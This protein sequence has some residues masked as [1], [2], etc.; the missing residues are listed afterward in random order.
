MQKDQTRTIALDIG[1]TLGWAEALDSVIVRSGSI[2]LKNTDER[3]GTAIARLWDFLTQLVT[4]PEYAK[5][6]K[7]EFAYEIVNFHESIHSAH[8][9]GRILG[10]VE[11]FTEYGNWSFV[12]YNVGVIKKNFTGK[13][14]AKKI[15]M[16][17]RCHQLGWK[18]GRV[19]TDKDN[20]EADAI[21]ILAVHLAGRNKHIEFLQERHYDPIIYPEA[22]NQEE[23]YTRS[24]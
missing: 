21:A 1:T 14:N 8:A 12:S 4:A 17:A 18:G 13:G 16:C 7:L 6:F 10:Q 2:K 19:G 9:F 23:V 15:D 24:W 22:K 5:D 20:D 3:W 11:K